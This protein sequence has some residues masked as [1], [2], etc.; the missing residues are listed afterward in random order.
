MEYSP[1]EL[2]EVEHLYELVK[3]AK[4]IYPEIEGLA[5]GAI[6]SS[7]QKVRVENVCKRHDLQSIACLWNRNQRELLSEMIENKMDSIL[8]KVCAMG[9]NKDDLMKSISQMKNKLFKLEEQYFVNVCGEGGEYESLT[10]DCP[11]FKRRINM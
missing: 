2:D 4:Q 5:S 3:K 11:L 10:L 9:L 1:N 6:L 8:I 7:Y